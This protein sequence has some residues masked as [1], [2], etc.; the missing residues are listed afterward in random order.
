LCFATQLQKSP[1]PCGRGRP[2]IHDLRAPHKRRPPAEDR[3]LARSRFPSGRK[4]AASAPACRGRRETPRFR[5]LGKRPMPSFQTASACRNR[6]PLGVGGGGVRRSRAGL[7]QPLQV[8]ADLQLG[9]VAQLVHSGSGGSFA[10]RGGPRRELALQ[11]ATVDSRSASRS[12]SDAATS[13]GQFGNR[14]SQRPATDRQQRW[15]H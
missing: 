8:E 15:L 10:G 11:R 1:R 14:R 2:V 5:P 3:Q 6:T 4:G 12:S 13:P 9:L 7:P